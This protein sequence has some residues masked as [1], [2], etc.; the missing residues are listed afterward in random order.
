VASEQ[1]K[2]TTLPS[3]Q[4]FRAWAQWAIKKLKLPHS[5]LMRDDRPSSKN[6]AKTGLN[7]KKLK[8]DFAR[9]LEAELFEQSERLGVEI[10]TWRDFDPDG[11]S[12]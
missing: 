2:S 9:E 3:S 4:I 5:S 10:G 12:R 6:R 11:F 1:V 8:L 7:A